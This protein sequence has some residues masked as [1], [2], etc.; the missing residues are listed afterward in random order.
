MRAKENLGKTVICCIVLA[1]AV[2][3]GFWGC[4]EDYSPQIR[5][6]NN[7]VDSVNQAV[8]DLRTALNASVSQLQASINSKVWVER[9][10][11]LSTMP[12]GFTLVLS[13][14]EEY[15]IRNGAN[16]TPGSTWTISSAGYWLCDGVLSDPPVKATGTNGT[17]GL[18]APPPYINASD[19]T[20]YLTAWNETTHKYDTIPSGIKAS[21]I[22]TFIA[23]V[24]GSTGNFTLHVKNKDHSDQW[25]NIPLFSG[26]TTPAPVAGTFELLGYVQGHV[27]SPAAN[28]S[29][30]AIIDTTILTMDCWRISDLPAEYNPWNHEKHVQVNQI[31]TT[32]GALHTALVVSSDLGASALN[33][34]SLYD[35]KGN[36][37]PLKLGAPVALTGFLTRSAGPASGTIYYI[38]IDSISGNNYTNIAAFGAQFASGTL[39]YLKNETTGVKSSF[40]QWTINAITHT[41]L[42]TTYPHV[43][44]VGG[45]A[46]VSGEYTIPVNSPV[47]V[48]FDTD[49]INVYDYYISYPGSRTGVSIGQSE[50]TFQT[51][52][53]VTPLDTVIVHK[54]YVDGVVRTD[55]LSFKTL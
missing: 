50:K 7:R 35:S 20:W 16:G 28:L 25:E 10:E 13:N 39:F 42:L 12:S 8:S 52:A 6:L 18:N 37:I 15:V 34:L 26:S 5:E 47:G 54:L 43:D 23:Y 11:P 31:L 29:L 48:S 21:G 33:N 30:R 24:T 45:A 4:S 2:T 36:A 53:A 9:V 32:L 22:E 55:T 3:G 46:A 38:P 49:S 40:S 17:N 14:G 1:F 19:T 41:A 44:K 51:N 27:I